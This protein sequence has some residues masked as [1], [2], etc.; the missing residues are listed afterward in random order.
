MRDTFFWDPAFI[1][2]KALRTG[3]FRGHKFLEGEGSCSLLLKTICLVP[4]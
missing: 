2:G 4:L 3:R 1:K